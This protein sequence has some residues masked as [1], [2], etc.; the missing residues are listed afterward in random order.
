MSPLK[1]K[2]LSEPSKICTFFKFDRHSLGEYNR[3]NFSNQRRIFYEKIKTLLVAFLV[4][5]AAGMLIACSSNSDAP[6]LDT[7]SNATP[8]FD[9]E[10]ATI[11]ADDVELSNGNWVFKYIGNEGRRQHSFTITNNL[12]YYTESSK[13]VLVQ[14]FSFSNNNITTTSGTLKLEEVFSDENK[15]AYIN[16]LN[17]EHATHPNETW[18]GNTLKIFDNVYTYES[19]LTW[20][21]SRLKNSSYYSVTTNED[22]TR[23]IAISSDNKYKYYFAKK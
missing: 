1:V 22:K 23:Y 3:R 21:R 5:I 6:S 16:F 18:Q 20:I 17:Q 10:D 11:P 19:E 8:L 2:C 15:T 14:N 7:S 9:E 4:V 13:E 12:I